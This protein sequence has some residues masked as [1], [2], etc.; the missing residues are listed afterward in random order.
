MKTRRLAVLGLASIA[1][2]AGCTEHRAHGFDNGQPPPSSERRDAVMA[3]ATPVCS[4]AVRTYVEGLATEWWRRNVAP[5]GESGGPYAYVTSPNPA[6]VALVSGLHARGV[7]IN[8][9]PSAHHW[10]VRD[11]GARLTLEGSFGDE[12]GYLVTFE[13]VAQGDALSTHEVSALRAGIR[14]ACAQGSLAAERP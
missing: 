13:L 14:Y 6:M 11:S 4:D 1:L 7:E 3:R 10:E 2:V 9:S 8:P 12:P 5:T